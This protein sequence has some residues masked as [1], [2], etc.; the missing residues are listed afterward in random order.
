MATVTTLINPAA[1]QN[2][3]AIAAAAACPVVQAGRTA[4]EVMTFRVTCTQAH[5]YKVYGFTGASTTLTDGTEL[6]SVSGKAASTG[7]GYG[8]TVYPDAW[9]GIAIVVTNNAAAATA[10]MGVYQIT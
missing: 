3:N 8:V 5:S 1:G 2:G 10:D 6:A 7:N 9:S 4:N